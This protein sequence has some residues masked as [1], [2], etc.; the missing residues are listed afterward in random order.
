MVREH[1]EAASWE[2]VMREVRLSTCPEGTVLAPFP[3]VED[4]PMQVQVPDS[5]WTNAWRA[6]SFQ[7]KGRHMWG[8]LAAEVARLP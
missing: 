5:G 3:R 6:A 8:G 1:R 4:P 7:M 2:E